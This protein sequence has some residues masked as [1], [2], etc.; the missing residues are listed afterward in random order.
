MKR[1]E[2]LAKLSEHGIA[3]IPHLVGLPTLE[4]QEEFE[5]WLDEELK[6]DELTEKEKVRLPKIHGAKEKRYIP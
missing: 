6:A 4:E 3:F 1:R 2:A 5:K